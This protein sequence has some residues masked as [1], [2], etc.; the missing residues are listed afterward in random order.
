MN[1]AFLGLAAVSLAFL[2]VAIYYIMIV[3]NS[4]AGLRRLERPWLLLECGVGSL[5]IAALTAPWL[6]VSTY[7][8]DL[9]QIL[10]VVLAA[11]FILTAMVLMKQAWTIREG[12]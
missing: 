8:L 5:F 3:K 9:V 2:A 12:D 10:A 7:L 11:F 1:S 4:F 6:N